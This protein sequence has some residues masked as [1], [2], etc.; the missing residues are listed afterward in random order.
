ML[1]FPVNIFC[2]IVSPLLFKITYFMFDIVLSSSLTLKLNC[3]LFVSVLSEKLTASTLGVFLLIFTLTVKLL[4]DIFF[5]FDKVTSSI[6]NTLSPI[7]FI[8]D[9]LVTYF[10]SSSVTSYSCLFI[11]ILLGIKLDTFSLSNFKVILSPFSKVVVC[12]FSLYV[13]TLLILNL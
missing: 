8:P 9:I 7:S 6:F 3:N 4:I 5:P 10:P 2:R 12:S 13:F 11:F 1:L